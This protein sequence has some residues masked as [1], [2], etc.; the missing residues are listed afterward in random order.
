MKSLDYRKVVICS[1]PRSGT[2][3]LSHS[4]QLERYPTRSLNR[5]EPFAPLDVNPLGALDPEIAIKEGI[6]RPLDPEIEL[7]SGVLHGAHQRDERGD[8]IWRVL[9]EID[10]HF[11]L[12]KREPF[13][14]TVSRIM[15]W[16]TGIWCETAHTGETPQD[17]VYV[18][19]KEVLDEEER[20]EGDWSRYCR[21]TDDRTRISISYGELAGDWRGTIRRVFEFLDLA[22]PLLENRDPPIKRQV[23]RPL[24]E[25]V[26]N[27]E[28]CREALKDRPFWKLHEGGGS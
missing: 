1:E 15:A 27:W 4:L 21:F 5:Y 3:L 13:A 11:I 26:S 6:F 18:P 2:Q 28:E 12:L 23:R 22:P 9:R 25:L 8:E 20:S 17:P 10:V 19:P 24:R 7:V 14:R 16:K